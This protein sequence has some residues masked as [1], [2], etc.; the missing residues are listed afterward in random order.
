MSLPCWDNERARGDPPVTSSLTSA[1][2]KPP[3]EEGPHKEAVFAKKGVTLQS[4]WTYITLLNISV[5]RHSSGRGCMLKDEE[6]LNIG[7]F[8]SRFSEAFLILLTASD[9]LRD[10][11]AFNK[12]SLLMC[13]LFL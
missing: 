3:V 4:H 1:S 2:Q 8:K 13:L 6:N 5:V 7:D 12:V 11:S 10:L 9:S